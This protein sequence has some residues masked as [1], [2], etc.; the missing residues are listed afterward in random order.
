MPQS[1]TGTAE[2]DCFSDL[3]GIFIFAKPFGEEAFWRMCNVEEETNRQVSKR[4][5][6]FAI[7][8]L[9][10]LLC[11]NGIAHNDYNSHVNCKHAYKER[12]SFVVEQIF[13]IARGQLD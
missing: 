3:T 13:A 1:V 7:N 4:P 11:R 2:L 8:F 12:Y 6:N 9:N 10:F 5:P